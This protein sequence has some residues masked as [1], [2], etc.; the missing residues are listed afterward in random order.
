MKLTQVSTTLKRR[1]PETAAE[2]LP[3]T[4]GDANKV[5]ILSASMPGTTQLDLV[6]TG[7]GARIS[8]AGPDGYLVSLS[9]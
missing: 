8:V 1:A 3:D 9:L 4:D 7:P 2:G 5:S 6:E